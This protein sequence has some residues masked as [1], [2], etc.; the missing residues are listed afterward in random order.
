MT[1]GV[2][3]SSASRRRAIERKL[4]NRQL[5]NIPKRQS[6]TILV[7]RTVKQRDWTGNPRPRPLQG[8]ADQASNEDP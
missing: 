1:T 7:Y 8:N 5:A 4:L 3:D 6:A 2:V